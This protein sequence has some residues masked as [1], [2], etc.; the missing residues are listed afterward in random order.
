MKLL[1]ARLNTL[2]TCFK[3]VFRQTNGKKIA[4]E[5]TNL[6]DNKTLQTKP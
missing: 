4:N 5:V 2:K 3:K 6:Y 1:D